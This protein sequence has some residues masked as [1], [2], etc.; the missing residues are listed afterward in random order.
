MKSMI[1]RIFLLFIFFSGLALQAQKLLGIQDIS[2]L[3]INKIEM[4]NTFVDSDGQYVVR[5]IKCKKDIYAYLLNSQT[6]EEKQTIFK[7]K[8]KIK[9]ESIS[10]S[11]NKG[12]NF[13]VY[14]N[15]ENDNW[16]VL[17]LDFENNKLSFSEYD[18]KFKS[19]VF[20][21]SL[22]YDDSHVVLSI[23]KNSSIILAHRLFPNGTV[24][25]QEFDFSEI[26][27]SGGKR[28]ISN[29]FQLI[30]ADSGIFETDVIKNDIPLSL[31]STNEKVK[32]YFKEEQIIL[33][34]DNSRDYTY[35]LKM[36]LKNDS[37]QH[38]T[39]DKPQM[40]VRSSYED[41][42]SFIFQENII[43]L[44]TTFEE[45]ILSITDL[46]TSNEIQSFRVKQDE[47]IYFKTSDIKNER[48]GNEQVKK[49]ITTEDFLEILTNAKP[50]LSLYKQENNFILTVGSSEEDN[51]ANEAAAVV[52]TLLLGTVGFA[53]SSNKNALDTNFLEYSRTRSTR[54]HTVFNSSFR[55][56]QNVEIAKNVFDKIRDYDLDN[57]IDGLK[58]LHKIYNNY[59][60]SF[61]DEEDKNIKTIEFKNDL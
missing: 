27:F 8:F 31:R 47:N 35:V 46:R 40:Q 59:Y 11:S 3:E 53:N 23:K 16:G 21:N 56:L 2:N 36:N 28:S 25:S 12:K 22:S 6:S 19:Q 41:S 5:F 29:L 50:A 4:F 1:K 24:I 49:E 45:M 32:I 30:R 18:F 44:K 58:S 55:V 43:Q 51:S 54:F 15:N 61:I 39:I 34:V 60:Y 33:T 20:L 42:N 14:L 13:S 38:K 7:E 37:I 52:G 48:R 10:G 57:D 17:S 9:Y 26:D